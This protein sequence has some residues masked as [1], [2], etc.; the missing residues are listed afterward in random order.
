MQQSFLF[1]S[2]SLQTHDSRFSVSE[3]STLQMQRVRCSLLFLFGLS[4]FLRLTATLFDQHRNSLRLS[5][6][7]KWVHLI[8]GPLL[9][10]CS[11]IN[12]IHCCSLLYI[13][14]SLNL[15][16]SREGFPST[17]RC[18]SVCALSHVIHTS[19]PANHSLPKL[20]NFHFSKFDFFPYNRPALRWPLN[21]LNFSSAIILVGFCPDDFIDI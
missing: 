1:V 16:L 6:I 14:K 21:D 17:S 8:N 3:I 9:N 19:Y 20:K 18:Q 15:P 11:V 5:P 13:G 12:S 4:N 7:S 10:Q 2:F